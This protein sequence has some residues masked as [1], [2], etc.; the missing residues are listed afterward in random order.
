MYLYV[1]IPKGFFPQQDTGRM[2]VSI[3]GAKDLSF[4]AMQQK[5]K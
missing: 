1:V 5:L 2:N 4:T 3:L